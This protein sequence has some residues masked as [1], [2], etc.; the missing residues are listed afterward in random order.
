MLSLDHVDLAIDDLSLVSD[1]TLAAEPGTTLVVTGPNGSGKSTLLQCIA[2]LRAV[3]GG[4]I[5]VDGVPADETDPDFRGLVAAH[6]GDDAVFPELTVAEHLELLCATRGLA[7]HIG[8]DM[9]V[10][11]GIDHLADRFPHTLSTGQRARFDLCAT[12]L[13]GTALVVLDEPETGLDHD[14]RAWVTRLVGAACDAGSVVV[15]A[16]HRPEMFTDLAPVAL[17]MGR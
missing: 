15:V 6:L 5:T 1:L 17:E 10:T 16:T 8:G 14:G 3:D 4:A 7:T 11:A 13:P 9:L 2:G 12:L